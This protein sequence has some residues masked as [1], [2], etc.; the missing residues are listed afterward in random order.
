MR[1]CHR[2]GRIK[3]GYERDISSLMDHA[4]RNEGTGLAKS[5]RSSADGARRSMAFALNRHLAHCRECG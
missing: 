5:S 1:T 2:F 4:T 3:S